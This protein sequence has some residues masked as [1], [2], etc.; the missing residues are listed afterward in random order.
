MGMHE[1]R[2]LNV[3]KIFDP[4]DSL[5]A[6]YGSD[7]VD[8]SVTRRGE[9]RWMVLAGQPGGVGATDLY[10][11]YLPNGKSFWGST[12]SASLNG[13]ESNGRISR[14]PRSGPP[15]TGSTAASTS[16]ISCITMAN[17]RC[18]TSRVL[19]TKTIWSTATRKVQ[20]GAQTGA[21][22]LSLPRGRRRCWISA[23]GNETAHSRLSFLAFGWEGVICHRKLDCVGAAQ[24]THQVLCPYGANR[25][26]S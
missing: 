14:N 23:F 20:M 16:P 22:T 10:I 9:H 8:A 15:R 25:V 4:S 2:L 1:C 3:S 13:T 17:G 11:A 26:R 5:T 19:T 6:A 24:K 12:E 21:N 7:L 18:G